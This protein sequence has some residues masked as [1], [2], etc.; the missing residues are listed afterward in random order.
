MAPK[1]GES[2]RSL[3][4]ALDGRRETDFDINELKN[5]LQTL[6]QDFESWKRNCPCNGNSGLDKILANNVIARYSLDG[7]A[8]DVSGNGYNGNKV[9]G[10]AFVAGGISG[11]AASF[12]GISKINVESLRNANWGSRFS[13]SVWFKRTGQ[14]QS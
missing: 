11:Q 8:N 4:E 12:N 10:V 3:R 1:V 9:G 6:I 14:W 13:V 5:A 2:C 7:D